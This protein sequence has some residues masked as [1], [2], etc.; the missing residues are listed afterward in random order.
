MNWYASDQFTK[1]ECRK[2]C[3]NEKNY[4][5]S[6]WSQLDHGKNSKGKANE[7]NKIGE[8]IRKHSEYMR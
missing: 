3:N 4:G 5:N 8:A 6:E 7:E 1:M 2:E